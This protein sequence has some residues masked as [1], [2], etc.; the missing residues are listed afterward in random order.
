MSGN[1]S[2]FNSLTLEQTRELLRS[3]VP[4]SSLR[5]FEEEMREMHLRYNTPYAR[6]Y[7]A[8]PPLAPVEVLPPV[9]SEANLPPIESKAQEMEEKALPVEE[10]PPVLSEAAPAA[11][12]SVPPLVRGIPPMVRGIPP[13]APLENAP[14]GRFYIP[15]KPLVRGFVGLMIFIYLMTCVIASKRPP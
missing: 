8:I 1:K 10:I 4:I 15:L 13:L 5:R 2:L 14:E 6:P 11:F 7:E 9:L 12:S 3:G